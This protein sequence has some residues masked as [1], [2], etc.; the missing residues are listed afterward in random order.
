MNNQKIYW[1]GTKSELVEIC[2]AL[3]TNKLIEGDNN[4]L[5][6][7]KETCNLV[8]DLLGVKLTHNPYDNVYQM[9]RRKKKTSTSVLYKSFKKCFDC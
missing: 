6:N 2:Y 8:F 3:Y 5:L 4:H 7:F 1:N 9:R